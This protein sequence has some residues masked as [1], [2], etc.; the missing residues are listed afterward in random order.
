MALRA[1]SS[2]E[3]GGREPSPPLTEH[4]GDARSGQG[5]R[6]RGLPQNAG[7]SG[8]SAWCA[9][10]SSANT[11]SNPSVP[12]PPKMLASCSSSMR[13]LAATLAQDWTDLTKG[14]Q[15]LAQRFKDASKKM[16]STMEMYTFVASTCQ[17]GWHRKACNI[18]RSTSQS[19]AST[20]W[21]S[22]PEAASPSVRAASCGKTLATSRSCLGA[23]ALLR[24]QPCRMAADRRVWASLPLDTKARKCLRMEFGTKS[25][26]DVADG[27][28]VSAHC[29]ST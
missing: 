3:Q 7:I 29:G 25:G 24:T 26:V 16:S 18:R 4:R 15:T 22:P 13:R 9:S 1:S 17:E 12:E 19:P 5:R 27:A 28:A 8:H 20:A 2:P 21:S 14:V 11:S 23:A 10:H 6:R